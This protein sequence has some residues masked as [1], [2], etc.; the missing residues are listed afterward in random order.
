MTALPDRSP[1]T[2]RPT[3]T[4]FFGSGEFAVP[5][6]RTLMSAA[7]ISV[8]GVVTPPD[9]P[10]G[11][12]A[13][14]TPVPVAVEAAR[15]GL[16][17]LQPGRLRGPEGAEAL[18]AL[19]ALQ[20]DLGVLADFGHIVPPAILAIPGH[21]ILNIHPSLLPRHRGATPIPATILAG[22]RVAGVTVMRMDAGL[23]T[24]PVVASTSW[25]LD[26]TESA[27]GLEARA[28]TEGAQLLAR[29]I[30]PYLRGECPAVPQAGD[31]DLTRPL[32]RDDGR[33]DPT[34]PAAGLE[35]QVRAYQP[36]P[37]AWVELEGG[38]LAVLVA[39][40]GESVPGDAP[41][42][43]VADGDGLALA[44]SRGRLRLLEVK[45]A[46]GRAMTGV[47]YRRGHPAVLGWTVDLSP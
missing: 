20:P 5:A 2:G 39:A 46:G 27:P 16:H 42:A 22:D 47:E 21:G 30:D 32:R 29:I 31:A 45:P 43:M 3:R 40:I 37:G 23:D 19:A 38:R 34:R 13:A 25:P 18:A 10:S 44:T 8:V 41:G 15:Q 9:R 26:G 12:R 28:A 33:L 11:R 14:P 6:L 24:G 7:G 36:W 35:R 1:A 17:V 4:V